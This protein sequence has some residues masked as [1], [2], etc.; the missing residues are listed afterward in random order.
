MGPFLV[1]TTSASM[2]TTPPPWLTSIGS[3][4]FALA[5]ISEDR[6]RIVCLAPQGSSTPVTWIMALMTGRVLLVTNPPPERAIFAPLLA[7]AITEGSSVAMGIRTSRPSMTKLV[8]IPRG[9]A[10]R[11]TTFSTILSAWWRV[12]PPVSIASTSSP[13]RSALS[14]TI[15]S[16]SEAER[17]YNPEIL[18]VFK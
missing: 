1:V 11:P 2:P 7:A 13:E 16:R 4:S 3:L 12:R 10:N 14:A 8:A 5:A 17:L 18:D 15:L 6:A 9:M